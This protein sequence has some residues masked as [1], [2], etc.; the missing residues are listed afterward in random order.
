MAKQITWTNILYEADPRFAPYAVLPPSGKTSKKKSKFQR[1]VFKSTKTVKKWAKSVWKCTKSQCG[2]VWQKIKEQ[3]LWVAIPLCMCAIAL[4]SWGM[5]L[6]FPMVG[7]VTA[8]VTAV[9]LTATLTG[10]VIGHLTS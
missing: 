10:A 6:L 7:T 1:M 3:P 2:K 9:Y 5:A 4:I 8:L